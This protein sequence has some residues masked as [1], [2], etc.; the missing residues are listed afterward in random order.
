MKN[1]R[2]LIAATA[3]LTGSLFSMTAW[4]VSKDEAQ[5]ALK[6]LKK[7]QGHYLNLSGELTFQAQEI[8]RSDRALVTIREYKINCNDLNI[9]VND[10]NGSINNIL[11]NLEN[12][13]G[14]GIGIE[15]DSVDK[16][17]S[18]PQKLLIHSYYE[19]NDT[20]KKLVFR[21][22]NQMDIKLDSNGKL[23]RIEV[24]SLDTEREYDCYLFK[25]LTK[26]YISKGVCKAL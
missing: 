17:K 25:T 18:G 6:Q 24:L 10:I 20:S 15:L 23:R 26:S 1:F 9:V 5:E 4:G 8:R 21:S 3:L 2:N 12:P 14:D 11:V 19:E 16:I 7:I 22:T 13:N